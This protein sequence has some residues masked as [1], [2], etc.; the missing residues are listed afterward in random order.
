MPGEEPRFCPALSQGESLAQERRQGLLDSA[1]Q[2]TG[3]PTRPGRSAGGLGAG[4]GRG[5]PGVHPG[6]RRAAGRGH[7]HVSR[8][9]ATSAWS[10]TPESPLLLHW[11]LAWQF[12]HE[13][14]LPPEDF[15]PAGSIPFDQ[16]AVRTPFAERDGLQYLELEF[17]KPAD[18][19]GAARDEVRP[20]PPGRRRLAQERRKGSS[21]SPVRGAGRSRGSPPRRSRNWPSRSSAPRWAPGPGP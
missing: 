15:R 14:Q 11:G 2:W 17:P 18:G 9:R 12:R 19:P 16:Q 20:V 4:A 1:D 8:G 3:R 13:W 6:Q 7:Q 5:P 10:A 21:T